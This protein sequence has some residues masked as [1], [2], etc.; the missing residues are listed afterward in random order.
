[1][2]DSEYHHH[3]AVFDTERDHL[4]AFIAD[5]K[6]EPLPLHRLK[7]W[8]PLVGKALLSAYIRDLSGVETVGKLYRVPLRHMPP[9][10]LRAEGVFPV[11]TS[12]DQFKK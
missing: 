3:T 5:V 1:M 7:Q 4:S 12:C 9:A 11:A 2:S 6:T 8:F 10:Y